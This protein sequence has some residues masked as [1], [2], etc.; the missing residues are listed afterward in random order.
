MKYCVIIPAY[1]SAEYLP[2]LVGRLKKVCDLSNV[3]VIDD[4]SQDNTAKVAEELGVEV[5]SHKAN[6]GKGKAL[7]TAF[8]AILNRDYE[9]IIT[10]DADLQHPPELAPKLISAL[11]NGA[12]FVVGNRMRNISKMPFERRMSNFLSTLATSLLAGR[13]L[14]DSQCG[15][16]AIK[17]WVVEKAALYCQK[18]QLE[19]EMMIEASRMGAKIEFVEIPTLYNG[20]KSYFHPIVDTARFISF[21]LLYYPQ[22]WFRKE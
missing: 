22:R 15:F 21:V 13:K 17:R 5:I 11:E 18:Y 19:S 6:R 7:R 14:Q 20:N 12:D 2:E 4:G 1:N 8:S 3:L 9:A 16:R 10:I